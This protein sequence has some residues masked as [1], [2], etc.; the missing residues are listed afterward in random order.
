MN[1]ILGFISKWGKCYYKEEQLDVLQ[2]KVSVIIKW[3]SFFV[4]QSVASDITK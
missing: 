2:S 3:G 1:F 4:L